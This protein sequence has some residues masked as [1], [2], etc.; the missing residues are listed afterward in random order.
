MMGKIHDIPVR[1][2]TDE[3]IVIIDN[4]YGAKAVPCKIPVPPL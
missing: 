4:R 2:C 3:M 1:D